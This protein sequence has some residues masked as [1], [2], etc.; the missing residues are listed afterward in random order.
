MLIVFDGTHFATA[1]FNFAAYLNSLQPILLTGVFLPQTNLANVWSRAGGGGSGSSFI[2]LIENVEAETIQRNIETFSRL[3]VKNNIDFRVHKDVMDLALP[4]LKRESRFADVMLISGETFYRNNG[5]YEQHE[6]LWEA[7]SEAECPL[8][9]LPDNAVNPASLVLAYD[10]TRSS[11]HAIKQF[12]YLFPELTNLPAL[13][14]Y[15]TDKGNEFPDETN[16]E[17]LA[18][19]HYPNLSLLKLELDAKKYFCTW[20]GEQKGALLVTGAYGRS[21]W[22]RLFKA[23]FIT[24]VLNEHLLPVFVA[25]K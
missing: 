5:E 12:A 4:E 21:G 16:I 8:I 23:S 25:H 1:A 22:S 7:L 24:D 14:M 3:C 11:V 2:P 13:L 9:V 17:E 20:L 6:Y 10:G 15:V 18:A 19:R